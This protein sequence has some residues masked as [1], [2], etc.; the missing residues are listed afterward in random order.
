MIKVWWNWNYG[1]VKCTS[2]R[3][4]NRPALDDVKK[5]CGLVSMDFLCLIG[6]VILT[7][8]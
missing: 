8:I 5:L 2:D 7:F 6:V 1:V 4:E 3:L